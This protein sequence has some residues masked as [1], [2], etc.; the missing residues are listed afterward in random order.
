M[1]LVQALRL[2]YRHEAWRGPPKV[3]RYCSTDPL[4]TPAPGA[5]ERPLPYVHRWTDRS[6]IYIS[7]DWAI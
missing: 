6:H 1:S 5:T 2:A 3:Q 4:R 7:K